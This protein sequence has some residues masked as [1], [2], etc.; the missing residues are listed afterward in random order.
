MRRRDQLLVDYATN[1][2]ELDACQAGRFLRALASFT[3]YEESDWKS[4]DGGWQRL[5]ADELRRRLKH[6]RGERRWLRA[7]VESKAF[8]R[9]YAAFSP[10][11]QFGEARRLISGLADVRAMAAERAAGRLIPA[12]QAHYL[13][14]ARC[15]AELR[16]LARQCPPLHGEWIE[17]AARRIENDAQL[18]I[19]PP[20]RN[21]WYVD[22][23]QEFAPHEL[24]GERGRAAID[25]SAF[26]GWMVRSL[27]RLVP[28]RTVNRAACIADLLTLSGVE[29]EGPPVTRML[30]AWSAKNR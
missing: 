20:D 19:P 28:E 3:W 1:P 5:P 11:T 2:R 22:P 16:K 23:W 15:V 7:V 24:I 14:H 29:I 13:D 12:D 4:P 18:H 6:R 27:A 17:E 21:K 26:R 10:E 25:A 8:T 9:A 30:E